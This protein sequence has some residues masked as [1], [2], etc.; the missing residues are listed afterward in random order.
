MTEGKVFTVRMS[1][2]IA[3]RVEFIARTDCVSVNEVFR[4]ALESYIEG[5]KSDE[6]FMER[7][8]AVVAEDARIVEE[9][10]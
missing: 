10:V 7:A 1:L 6:G 8:R 4:A 3:R 2:E 9:L 5:K